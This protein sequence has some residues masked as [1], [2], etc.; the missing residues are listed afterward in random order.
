MKPNYN[1]LTDKFKDL[2]F[3]EE[4][5]KYTLA[6]DPE[7]KF[8]SG[9]KYISETFGNFFDKDAISKAIS[10]RDAIP[11]QI[12]LDEW[13]QNTI[14]SLED[15]NNVHFYAETG[16]IPKGSSIRALRM[17][18]Q[19]DLYNAKFT[20]ENVILLR[21]FRMF[22]KTISG[23][24]DRLNKN[25]KTDKYF[26]SDFKTN[27]DLFKGLDEKNL[28]YPFSYF[29][30]CPYSKYVLQLNLYRLVFEKNF[31][32]EM[33]DGV[34]IWLK[35]NE[36]EELIVPDLRKELNTELCW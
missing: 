17:M 11:Q 29:F 32:I 25:I 8:T 6:S 28:K 16:I 26:F 15:G 4:F 1:F 31:D 10:R 18:N 21:E 19:V 34:I 13:E 9:T 3:N 35:E 2:E 20:L 5:H 24:G 36:Y 30:D 27:K 22:Y 23:T 7:F 33:G 12:I 14:E